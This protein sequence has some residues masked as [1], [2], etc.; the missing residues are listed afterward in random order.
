M[1]QEESYCTVG[2]STRFEE[3]KVEDIIEGYAVNQV[4]CKQVRLKYE[5]FIKYVDQL[6]D[7]EPRAEVKSFR[8]II[9]WCTSS[10]CRSHI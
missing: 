5:T 2:Q 4:H 6:S 1:I 10:T 9:N 7:L 3:C 8:L